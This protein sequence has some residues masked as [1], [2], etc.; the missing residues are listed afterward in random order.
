MFS[1]AQ[2]RARAARRY[3]FLSSAAARARRAPLSISSI[4]F[5]DS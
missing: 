5:G 2:Q 3:R 1:A 4:R